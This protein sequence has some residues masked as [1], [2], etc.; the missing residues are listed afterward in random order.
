MQVDLYNPSGDIIGNVELHNDVFGIEPNEYA[1]HQYV[2]AYLAH[3]RQGTRKT[4]TR[5][6]VSGG[7]KK[8]W[9]QKGRGTARA[10]SS[11]SPLWSGGGKIHG[12]IPHKYNLKVPVKIKRLAK[13]SALS[14][15]TAENRLKVLTDFN[16]NEYK[17]KKVVELLTNL[18]L[19]GES[20]LILTNGSDNYFYRSAN[21]IP[22]VGIQ[23]ADKASAFDIMKYKNI[24]LLQNAIEDIEKILL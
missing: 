12:P 14:I 1:I 11:R 5:A 21:N 20:T 18:K 15:R 2:L 9:R 3:Q 23:P 7:G 24:V 22:K 16:I 19:Y 17:T 8:P 13:K 4:K 6:E 10:G